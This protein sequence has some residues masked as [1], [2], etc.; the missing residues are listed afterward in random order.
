VKHLI[1]I[2]GALLLIACGAA[3]WMYAQITKPYKGFDQP[4]FVEFQHGTSTGAMADVLVAKG[5]VR[6]RWEF[7][8]AR[9]LR[10][11]VTLQAGEYRFEKPN[12]ALGVLARIA[13]GD[14]YYMELLIPEGYNIFDVAG[15][16]EKLGTMSAET[17]LAAARDPSLIR[18]IDPT[19]ETLEGYLFPNKYRVYRHTTA[20]QICKQMTGEFRAQWQAL[21]GGADVHHAVTLASLVE[22]EAKLKPEQPEISSVF[23]NRLKIGMKLDCDPTTIYAS[24]LD[25]HWR[26]VIH[27]SELDSDN[28]YN[29]YKHVGLPPG[30][31]ANP[32]LGA[33]KAALQPADTQYLY[34]VAKADG[35]GGHSFSDS[36]HKHL[37]AVAQYQHNVK[38]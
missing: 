7:L 18:D 34:F 29:T 20:Q 14:I 12:S 19:A 26:G 30:P 8:L 36:L 25:G 4:V 32:G 6:S 28:P 27:R 31:I 15:A 33:L 16:V 10:R 2:A 11:G 22:R 23:H 38:H 1:R 37:A 5:V 13:R 24:L 35:S 9:A 3:V 17:F 21:G